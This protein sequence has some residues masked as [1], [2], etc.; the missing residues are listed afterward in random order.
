MS[1]GW[2]RFVFNQS[3][4]TAVNLWRMYMRYGTAP[5]RFQGRPGH[6][7]SK[8]FLRI[9]DLQRN[10]TAFQTPEA[11]LR[12]VGL[13]GLTQR[14]LRQDLTVRCPSAVHT[15]PAKCCLTGKPPAHSWTA[16]CMC[17]KDGAYKLSS[18]CGDRRAWATMRTC[19]A[20]RRSLSA[21]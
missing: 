2:D 3:T 5:L 7:F 16:A 6:M 18:S 21:P 11:L 4:W 19:T 15:H 14:S 8:H 1:R 10:G 17:N 13:F 20:L 9:Y 12:R